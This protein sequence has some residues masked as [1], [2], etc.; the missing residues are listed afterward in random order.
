MEKSLTIIPQYILITVH[1][2]SITPS[3]FYKLINTNIIIF[4]FIFLFLFLGLILYSYRYIYILCFTFE[5]CNGMQ[6][7][8]SDGC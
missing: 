2:Y 8:N 3:K 1:T 6:S 5:T 4:C 7:S